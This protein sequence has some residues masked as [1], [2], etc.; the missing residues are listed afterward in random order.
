ME[1]S[2]RYTEVTNALGAL[3]RYFGDDLGRAVKIVDAAG[4]VTERAFDPATGG[5][6]G[7]AGPD[8]AGPRV[9]RDADGAITMIRP[10]AAD[11][12]RGR[13]VDELG[14]EVAFD[15]LR[16]GIECSRHDAR[17]NLLFAHHAD[18]TRE[19]FTY[20]ERGLLREYVNRQGAVSRIWHD[21]MGNSTAS[22]TA[23]RFEF[24]KYDYLGRR[25]DHIDPEPA[26]HRVGVRPPERGG[27][28][29]APRRGRG[30]GSVRR[31]PQDCDAR[32]G[33]A[34]DSV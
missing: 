20:D 27:L 15:E 16:G 28:E 3:T 8:G 22:T 9:E 14:D 33:R 19:E 17:G 12:V 4:G 34:R 32:R 13:F 1:P 18:G 5:L 11:R 25:L 24:S 26:R 2:Q 21:P 30:A 6:V 29:E 7:E 31:Q 23:G 10:K